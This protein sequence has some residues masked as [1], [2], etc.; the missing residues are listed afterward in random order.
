MISIL[1]S[2]STHLSVFWFKNVIDKVEVGERKEWPIK[3]SLPVKEDPVLKALEDPAFSQD[4][5]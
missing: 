2:T 5:H 4:L 3:E 1:Y